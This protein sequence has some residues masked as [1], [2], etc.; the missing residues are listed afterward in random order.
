MLKKQ[1]SAGKG[2]WS[3][4]PAKNKVGRP[5]KEHGRINMKLAKDVYETIK[6]QPSCTEFVEN[7]VREWMSKQ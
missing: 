6:A 2:Q 5:A 7:L 1:E 4:L 3:D